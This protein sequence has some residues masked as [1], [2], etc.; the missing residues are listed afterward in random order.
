MKIPLLDIYSKHCETNRNLF[1]NICFSYRN[2]KAP[3][4][5]VVFFI[6]GVSMIYTNDDWRYYLI[7][8][9]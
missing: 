5:S 9:A 2:A 1:V 3:Y 7:L 4:I 6:F 8:I